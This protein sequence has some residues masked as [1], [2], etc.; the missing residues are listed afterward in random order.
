MGWRNEHTAVVINNILYCW[1]GDQEDLPEVHDS[2]EKKKI[3]S[4]IDL[5]HLPTFTWERSSTTGTPPVGVFS[6]AC[7]NI[8]KP[9]DCFHNNL[10]ELNSVNN[11]CG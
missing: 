6:Y 4:S 10:Y 11:N 3:T 7:T 2:E 5:F 9:D 8:D 1:G